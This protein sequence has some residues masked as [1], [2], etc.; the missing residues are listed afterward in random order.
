MPI[1][2]KNKA[3]LEEHVRTRLAIKD[4]RTMLVADTTPKIS[5]APTLTVPGTISTRREALTIS[6]ANPKGHF[7]ASLP[8]IGLTR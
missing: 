1:K 5:Y 6:P 4:V 8:A 7:I 2:R 3:R